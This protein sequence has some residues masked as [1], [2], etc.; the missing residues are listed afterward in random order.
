MSYKILITGGAGYIGSAL[1][2][3]LVSKNYEVTVVDRLMYKIFPFSHLLRYKN[4]KFIKKNI[5]DKNF[6]KTIPLKKYDIII[7]LAALVG[8]PLCEKKKNMATRLNYLHIK[9]L[10][11]KLSKKQKILFPT[12]N[13]GYGIGSKNQYCDENS[14]LNPI[15]HYGR[16]KMLAEKS[17]I[18]F[19]NSISFRLATVFGYSNRMRTDLLVNNFVKL[20]VNKKKISLY[21]SNFR[22]NFIHINDVCRAFAFAIKN[23]GRMKGNIYNLGLSKANLTK[24][25][26]ARKIS[27]QIKNLKILKAVNKVDPDKRDYFVSNEKIEKLGFKPEINIDEGIRELIDFY[28]FNK[29]KII[30]NY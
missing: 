21:E 11:T 8:A 30:N 7:P 16:T 20:A 22:R 18:A 5:L 25:Q 15:S 4:F 10:I 9:K 3:H 2:E 28:K 29:S 12:T 17:V 1:T 6:F 27:K 19:K 26:L 14:P 24:K 23:F 13:S